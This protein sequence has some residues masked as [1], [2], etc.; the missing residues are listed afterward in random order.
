MLVQLKDYLKSQ[1]LADH[2]YI[3]KID[4]AQLKV[5]GVYSDTS[6]R[7]EAFGKNSSYEIAGFKILVHWNRNAKE[8]EAEANLVYETLRYITNTEMT[9]IYVAFFDVDKPI[10]VG[11]DDNNVYEYVINGRIYFGR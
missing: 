11:T 6:E 3:G 2:Y 1:S 10:F 4:N 7:V 5:L 8:S 9:D